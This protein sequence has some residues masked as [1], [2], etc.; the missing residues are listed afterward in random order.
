LE[1]ELLQI[2]TTKKEWEA[3]IADQSQSRGRDVHLEEAQ[4]FKFY[5]IFVRNSLLIWF[6][7]LRLENMN[8]L[9][10]K[11]PCSLRDIY[12]SSIP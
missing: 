9:R 12:K 8:N 5:N 1:E 11:P 7:M 10:R 4:V 2:E 3:A 6:S